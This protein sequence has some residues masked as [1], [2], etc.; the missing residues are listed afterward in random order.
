MNDDGRQYQ[1]ESE[2]DNLVKR[3]ERMI[4]QDDQRYFDLEE[5]EAIISHYLGFGE[6]QNAQKVLQYASRLFPESLTLQ[7]R[8]AQI[9][10]GIGKHIQAI[11]RLNNLL[12]FEPTNEEIHLT[13]ASIYS[14][15][16]E[17]KQAINHFRNA[18]KVS[19]DDMKSDIYIDISIEYQSIG[20]WRRAL[21]VLKQAISID[22]SNESALY[23]IAFCYDKIDC[24]TDAVRFFNSYI[25]DNPYSTAAWYN[26]GNTYHRLGKTKQAVDSYDFSIAIDK[27]FLRAYH[28]K[29]EALTAAEH[30]AD[31]LV[32]YRDIL[33]VEDTS[34][35]ILCNIGECYERLGELEKAEEYYKESL[36]IDSE[37]TDAFVGLGVLADIQ[38][39][40][41][42]AVR[43][44][45]HAVNLDEEHQ[46]IRLLL[47]AALLK[48]NKPQEAET[49]YSIVLKKDPKNKEA[50]E[51]RIFNLQQ[52]E[53]HTAAL[54]AL[55]QGLVVIKDNTHLLYLQFVSRFLSGNEAKAL[56][57]LEQLLTHSFDSASRV[58]D[59]FPLLLNDERIA[60]RYSSLKP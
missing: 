37:F 34:A 23:E 57:Q 26:L 6:L 3:F 17:H 30:Y 39:Q 24:M 12:L 41:V 49:Q 54:E 55:E 18:L 11:P 27:N 40:P 53:A 2:V 16:K 7:L 52:I 51:G 31:A 5:F 58:F 14:Q 35:Y 46:D 48:L 32:A 15:I 22:T 4:E 20:E 47:A 21:E 19:D 43:Y 8:E 50:W 60:E 25:D 38:S 13:L 10:A 1:G 33:S 56:D 59:L 44:F 42:V 9:L 45:E 29:A 28:Q 36:D